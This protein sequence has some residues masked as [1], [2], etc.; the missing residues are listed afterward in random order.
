MIGFVPPTVIAQV[1]P[2]RPG[3]ATRA[4]AGRLGV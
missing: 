3:V 4:R 2:V 1:A